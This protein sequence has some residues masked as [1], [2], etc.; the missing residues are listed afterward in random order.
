MNSSQ[1]CPV[2]GNERLLLATDGSIFSEGATREAIA[3]AKK[4]FSKLY[5][6]FVLE[7]NPEYEIGI[8]AAGREEADAKEYLNSI[9]AKALEEGVD[10]ETIFHRGLEAYRHIVDEASKRH[11][12][13]IIIG[14]HGRKGLAKLL[15]GE[16]AAKVIGHAPCRVLVVPKAAKI[17]YKKILVATDGSK[18]SEAA[19]LEAINI[20]ERCGSTVIA[21]SVSPSEDDL[22]EAKTNVARVVEMA[23]KESI[24]IEALTPIGSSYDAIVEVAGG[25]GIDLIV[26]GTY[27]KTGLKKL[28]MGSVTEKVIGYAGCAVLVM[29][30]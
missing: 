24:S 22:Q 25:R 12:D 7:S 16:D 5:T 9:R 18:H 21:I 15:M 4:C 20:A 11:I 26:M 13:M 27:G 23:Q 6:I 29:K 2:S 3:F 28:L 17:E 14:R 19:T 1:I 30:A 10:C 8:N